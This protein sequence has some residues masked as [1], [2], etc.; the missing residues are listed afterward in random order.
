ML[1]LRVSVYFA[2]NVNDV[3]FPDEQICSFVWVVVMNGAF[4]A[5]PVKCS[6][7]DVAIPFIQQFPLKSRSPVGQQ[8]YIDDPTLILVSHKILPAGD[9][10]CNT[11]DGLLHWVWVPTNTSIEP[12]GQIDVAQEFVSAW[13]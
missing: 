5:S 7:M 1:L 13:V 2:T 12:A 3:E 6:V 9:G 11:A 4:V 8:L 10:H